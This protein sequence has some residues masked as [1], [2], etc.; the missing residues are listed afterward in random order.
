MKINNN[1]ILLFLL[2]II[3]VSSCEEKKSIL[4][5]QFSLTTLDDDM[6]K[7]KK[8][9]NYDEY[10]RLTHAVTYHKAFE[11]V[12]KESTAL[13]G[14]EINRTYREVMNLGVADCKHI[15]ECMVIE[16][17]EEF[18]SIF[19]RTNLVIPI[20]DGMY[21]YS[22]SLGGNIYNS[23]LDISTDDEGFV[24]F[25]SCNGVVL[26]N[27]KM[28]DYANDFMDNYWHIHD[29][30]FTEKYGEGIENMR[31]INSEMALVKE[32]DKDTNDGNTVF[33]ALQQGNFGIGF[34]YNFMEL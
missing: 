27:K 24:R 10:Q 19:E 16:Y 2:I 21:S 12:R 13:I 33:I 23:T 18:R 14:E 30:Y 11:E 17:E 3:T 22:Y 1:V 29:H 26:S 32:W 4:D 15:G 28:R 34:T 8:Q 31:L 9:L 25:L 7:L 20:E 5:K 6:E